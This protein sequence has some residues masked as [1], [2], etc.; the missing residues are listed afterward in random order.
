[1]DRVRARCWPSATFSGETASGWQQVN[2]ATP[3]ADHREH[4]LRRLLLRTGR[5]TTPATAATSPASGVDNAPAA[6]AG[7]RCRR[8]QRRLRRTASASGFPNQHLQLRATTGSTRVLRRPGGDRARPPRPQSRPPG[9]R[10]GAGELDAR[11]RQRRQRDHQLHGHPV[12]RRRA[13]QTPATV[14]RYSAA[15]TQTVTGLTNGTAYTFTVTATNAVGAGRPRPP[16]NPSHPPTVPG[17]PT[18]APRR[19]GTARRTLTWTAP[20]ERRR[21]DHRLHGHPLLGRGDHRPPSRLPAATTTTVTGLTNGTAYTF[22]VTATNTAGTG[23]ASTPRAPTPIAG[24]PCPAPSAASTVAGNGQ[25]TLTWTAPVSD[26]GSAVVSY[27]ITPFVAGVAQPRAQLFVS[28]ATT[29]NHGDRAHQ[30][31]RLHLHRH[32]HQRPRHQ[33]RLDRLGPGHPGPPAAARCT[34]WA[35]S[36]TPTNPSAARYRRRQAGGEVPLRRGR[37]HHRHPLLQGGRQHRH[38]RRPPLDQRPG[39]CWPRR[40]SAARRPPAGSRSASPRRW[41]SPPTPPTSRRTSHPSA[42]TPTTQLLRHRGRGQRRRCT[43]C[44]TA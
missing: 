40:P 29:Q 36:A 15:T 43:R 11:P 18:G 41:R 8:R 14:T 7:G 17:A 25:A 13:A 19:P 3:G 39:R 16:P 12:H 2:F 1:M 9:Q 20:A 5:A 26:G 44:A 32:G 33:R 35:S 30:R 38:A 21:A 34:I 10:I 27:T 22:T 6:R 23:P 31:H 37:D 42:A 28:A 24:R 4:R